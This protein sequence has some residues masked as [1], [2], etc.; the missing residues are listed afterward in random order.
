MHHHDTTKTIAES[1]L[2]NRV[3]S[4]QEEVYHILPELK[5]RRI[6]PAVSYVNTNTLGER[7]Q[8]LSSEKEISGLPDVSLNIF[9]KLNIG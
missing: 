6:F 4:I 8:V 2:S 1:Y 9:K 7:V 5:L 3:C